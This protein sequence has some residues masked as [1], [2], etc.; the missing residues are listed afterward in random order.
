VELVVFVELWRFDAPFAPPNLLI[1][2]ES[3][4]SN[5]SSSCATIS[6][7]KLASSILNESIWVKTMNRPGYGFKHSVDDSLELLAPHTSENHNR[8]N[9]TRV[10]R[11]NYALWRDGI[12]DPL[13]VVDVIVHVDYVILLSIHL[14]PAGVNH[15]SRVEVFQ[16]QC[17]FLVRIIGVLINDLGDVRAGN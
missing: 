12:I 10:H 1:S 8:F 5:A 11:L 13:R 7:L 16:Q 9:A 4:G 6:W 15:R 3:L 2:L 17:L 14:T